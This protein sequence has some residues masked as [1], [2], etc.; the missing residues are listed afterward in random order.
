MRYERKNG[1]IAIH[2]EDGETEEEVLRAIAKAAFEDSIAIHMGMLHYNPNTV[3]SDEQANMLMTRDQRAWLRMDYVEG[4]QVKIAVYMS[5]GG[6]LII[7]ER[8]YER[9]HRATPDSMLKRA[10][11][12]LSGD[13][14]KGHLMYGYRFKGRNLDLFVAKFGQAR[15]PGEA[16][17]AFRKRIFPDL[18]EQSHDTAIMVLF[19][20]YPPTD[21]HDADMFL[22]SDVIQ[23]GTSRDWLIRFAEGFAGDPLEH[24]E[25]MAA[26]HQN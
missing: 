3:L 19:G 10:Q 16:D 1:Y 6:N 14:P 21:F 23:N 2:V 7:D 4:R 15:K 12:I 17:W 25:Q 9:D 20:G 22:A 24:R 13:E 26:S 11:E 8:D 18:W 5:Q